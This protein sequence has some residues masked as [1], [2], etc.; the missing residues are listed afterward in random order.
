V[1]AHCH[2]AAQARPTFYSRNNSP[3]LPHR[4]AVAINHTR[5]LGLGSERDLHKPV[6][7]SRRWI[8][9]DDDETLHGARFMDCQVVQSNQCAQACNLRIAAGRLTVL[10]NQVARLPHGDA[11]EPVV[12]GRC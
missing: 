9:V 3:L 12:R 6:E 8:R 7:D 2:S 5:L 10:H 4:M 1:S 11:Q